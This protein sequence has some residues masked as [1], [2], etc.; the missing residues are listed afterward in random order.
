MTLAPCRGRR[1]PARLGLAMG[2]PILLAVSMVGL[3]QPARAATAITVGT[4]DESDLDAAVAQGNSD[5][6]GDTITFGCS[7]T[8]NLSS[9]LDI[10]GDMTLD[11]TGQQVTVGGSGQVGVLSVASGAEFTLTDVTVAG[12]AAV[13]G[14]GLV[15]NG[16]TVTITDSTFND[17]RANAGGGLLNTGGGTVTITNSTFEVNYATNGPGSAV[18]NSDGTVDIASSLFVANQMLGGDNPSAVING[19]GSTM[20]ITGSDFFNNDDGGGAAIY[21]G[22]DTL[23]VTNSTVDQNLEGG[24]IYTGDAAADITFST[25][26]LNSLYN[27]DAG[28]R[29]KVEGSILDGEVQVTG[30]PV[31]NC[32]G[33]LVDQGYNLETGTDC[34]FTGTGDLQNAGP[35]LAFGG[36]GTPYTL[37]QGSPAIDAVPL[38]LCPATD[39]NG[40]PRPDDP[41]ETA[42]D[43][44]ATESNYPPAAVTVVSSDDG[45]SILGDPVTFTATFTP[46][47]GGG[48]VAFYADGS[49]TPISGCG[50]QALTQA[51]GT[52]YR[53]TCTTSALPL[54]THTISATYSG[55]SAYPAI[56]GSLP[57]GQNVTPPFVSVLTSSPN[58]SVY[59]QPV[60]FTATITPTDGTG[61]VTFYL[62]PLGPIGPVGPPIS[63]CTAQPLTQLSGPDYTA[64]CTTSSLQEAGGA[65]I[66]AVYSGG[67]HSPGQSLSL[68]PGQVVNPAPLTADVVGSQAY[69]G[70]PAF[71]VTGYAGLV[72]GDTPAVVGGTLTGCTTTV[73]PGAS[74]GVHT[75]TISGCSGLS[76]ANYTITYAD[77]GA[78]VS[79]APL[80]ARVAGS[81]IYGGTPA[82]TVTGYS[83]LVNGDAGSVVGGSLTGCTTSVG[84]GAST[85]TYS[86]TISG[87]GGLSSP[88]Y[89][90]SYTD[91]GLTVG[92]APLAITASSGTMTYGGTPPAITPSYAGFVNGDAPG[93][94]TTPPT[95]ATTATPASPASTY[96]TSC[97][98]AADP[99]YSISY[100]PG[101]VTVTQAGQAISVTAPATGV[102][103]KTA[104]LA[105]TG[106]GSGNPVT[107]TVDPA[108]GT[109]VCAVTGTTVAYTAAGDC[110]IDAN[111][112][113][114][115]NYAPAPQVTATITVD[116]APAFVLDSP[117]PTAA[118]GQPYDYT[119][120]ASGTPAPTYTLTGAPSWLSVNAATGEVTGTPP[121]GTT[122]FSYTITATNSAGTA[123][124]GPFTVTV[125]KPSPDADISAALACPA[126]MTIG[127]TGTCTLTIANAG[128]ATAA[129]VAAGVLLPPT[130]SKVSCTSGCAQHAN[131]LTWTL[132]TLAGGASAKLSITIKASATGKATVLAAA[133]S[134]NPDPSPLNN[135]SI[136]QIK[137]TH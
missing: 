127:G 131:V 78:T 13:G 7:G 62:G 110:V 125:T 108:S 88:N 120:T 134:Q 117:P 22:G 91:A 41:A 97:S 6:A 26:A 30:K 43:M 96:P 79:P 132:A 3:A 18:N 71:T 11:G 23:T 54:G 68:N 80:A 20:S 47:D 44:G 15:N 49:A 69:G 102:V 122:T 5:N 72:N 67:S 55:D 115:A 114:N 42:C 59:G 64:T 34:G 93:S 2:L 36:A 29:T 63:G 17:N 24:G 21:D 126:S 65:A 12:G 70:T 76:A 58:P 8:I 75:G 77:A 61:F 123:T 74:V 135:I 81:Q 48:S 107:F 46:T 45:G 111:Q 51:T 56:T 25:L 40:N 87:C 39:E 100:A 31:T 103:G 104:T 35:N 50:D 1:A 137:I 116:Q 90:L 112:A 121:T 9:T 106:G 10:T 14:G 89:T 28:E 60:T 37:Q 73:G 133:A 19:S 57:G 109:G 33:T 4:C 27:L 99:D 128:P 32:V 118:A 98:G 101:T 86:G 38:A 16:G 113:G 82:F 92:P 130:L 85:G 124:A 105:A 119:F 136:Q 52:T 84:P 129:K 53:A 94:L 66:S 83:G 95:C